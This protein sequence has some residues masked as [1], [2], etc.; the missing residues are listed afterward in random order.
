MSNI[1]KP[2]NKMSDVSW[3]GFQLP[4]MPLHKTKLSD[5]WMSYLW[6]C[7]EQAE[8]DNVNDSNDY[9]YRLAGNI[10]GSLGLKDVNNKF[11]DEVVGPLTQ[12][13]LDD[14]PKHYFPPIDLD[15]SLDLKYK[16]EFRLNWWVNYQYATE[17]NPEHG[18]TGITSFVI[19][20]KIPTHYEEQHNLT[21]H[22]KAASDFQFT[23]TDILGNT[24]EYPILMSPEMEGTLMLFP[25]SLHHQ[26]YPFYNTEKPRI[27]IAGNL[28]WNVVEL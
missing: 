3:E 12:Q 4:N 18:H 25:S 26:V 5:D 7:V 14:D 15:P 20:M 22:S 10:T 2:Y 9:S 27:S 28:L 16:P 19:W 21:F 6:S 24:I 13:L 17:F 8:K 23:Y 1:P 11:R